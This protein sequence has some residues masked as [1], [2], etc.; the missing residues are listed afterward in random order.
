MQRDVFTVIVGGKAGQGVKKAGAI[1]AALFTDM[2]RAAF[3]YDDY[4]SLIRG[5]HNFA[6]VSTAPDEIDSQY[7]QAQLVVALDARSYDAH[8]SHLAPGGVM[9]YNSDD[10]KEAEGIGIPLTTMAKKYPPADL[11][12]GVTS[13]AILCAALCLDKDYMKALLEREYRRDLENNVAYANE[14]YDAASPKVAHCFE[15]QRGSGKRRFLAGAEAIALGAMAAG[16]DLYFA[17]PMTP[18]TSL[19]HFLAARG[20]ALGV[21]VMHP[22]NEIAVANIAIGAT[23]AGARTMVG[24]SG[25]GFALME[26]AFSLAG[27]TEA[28]ILFMLASRP[29]PATGV[30]TYTLQG[31]LGF[32]LHQGHGEFPRI[33]ASPGTVQD[34][35]LLTAEMLSLV[36]RFQTPGILLTEKHM[37]E[38]SAS[39]TLDLANAAWA[40]P[41]LS[42]E[43]P[44]KRYLDTA[45]GVSPLL[46]PPS[47][48]LIKWNSYEHDELGITTEAGEIVAQMAEKRL[49][50]GMAIR[51]YLKT[52]RTVNTYGEGDA[53]I[54]TYGSTT[55]SVLEALRAGD[56]RATV[57]QPRFLDPL[58]VW[59]LEQYR[60]RRAIVVEQSVAGQFATLLREKA[61]IEAATV[62]RRYD[63]RPFEP[64][65]LA[66]EIA[67]AAGAKDAEYG[68]RDAARGIRGGA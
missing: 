31:D 37:T 12:L 52:Q 25:G 53:L 19:L 57:V 67:N 10:G 35:F 9:I 17:Y 56:I 24:S 22:E 55:M 30:P 60:G 36:W 59:E 49:R 51:D 64:T 27:I 65:E 62:I 14:V 48:E 29:G 44:Y 34:A 66:D 21:T 23:F 15:L 68:I 20:P 50:K 16:L 2:E 4:P 46:F 8:R 1:A 3:Q 33:V 58:P 28:P 5:G 54:F 61:G 42:A 43:R 41:I 39:V 63:G 40:E 38:C 6:V 45:D 13:T 47:G 11:R 7:L 26:E 32:A 18:T